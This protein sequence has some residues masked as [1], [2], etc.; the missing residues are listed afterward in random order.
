MKMERFMPVQAVNG[1]GLHGLFIPWAQKKASSPL[2]NKVGERSRHYRTGSRK[3]VA[4][5]CVHY[6]VVGM[7]FVLAAPLRKKFEASTIFLLSV[8]DGVMRRQEDGIAL[9]GGVPYLCMHQTSPYL[10]YESSGH[11][12][13]FDHFCR[14]LERGRESAGY[15]GRVLSEGRRIG[16][17]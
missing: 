2:H 3:D 14:E 8:P 16:G 9:T 10:C 6:E 17:G 7:P 11:Q 13:A 5:F 15:P 12:R 4:R 1:V